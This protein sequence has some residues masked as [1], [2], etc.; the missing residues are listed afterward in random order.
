VTRA[1]NAGS[2]ARG[3]DRQAYLAAR[4]SAALSGLATFN[5]MWR[6]LEQHKIHQPNHTERL[7][8]ARLEGEPHDR[9]ALILAALGKHYFLYVESKLHQLNQFSFAPAHPREEMFVRSS[10]C[11]LNR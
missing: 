2:P 7:C 1:T 11:V 3:T 10:P 6:R 9:G 5:D 4:S 8:L